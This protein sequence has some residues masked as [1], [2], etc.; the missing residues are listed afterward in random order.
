MRK[1][2]R[3]LSLFLSALFIMGVVNIRPISAAT[4]FTAGDFQVVLDSHRSEISYGDYFE[5]FKGLEVHMEEYEIDAADYVRTDNMDVLIFENF[6]GME[7]KSVLTLEEGVI[8]WEVNVSKA[9]LYNV[10]LIYFPYTG[11]SSDIQ[12]SIFINGILPFAEAR[13]VE[14]PRIWVNEEKIARVDSQ[15]NDVKPRQ[16]EA[17][18]WRR[19]PIR[20]YQG[21]YNE[22]FLF[23]LEEGVNTISIVS[24]REPMM[25]RKLI[26]CYEP[27]PVS[28]KEYEAGI[29]ARY[30]FTPGRT[31]GEILTIEAESAQKKSS[32]M[33]YPISDNSNLSVQPNSARV[34]RNNSIGG[35]KWDQ[36]GQWIE[37]EFDVEQ[38]GF[39]RIGLN[40]KQHFARDSDVYRRISINDEVL[41]KEL[42]AYAF[43]YQRSWRTETLGDETGDFMFYLTEGRHTL[44]MEVVLGE[45]AFYVRD[46][47]ERVIRLNDIYR[48][49]IMI[50][51]AEPDRNRDY[52]VKRTLPNLEEDMLREGTRLMEVYN[53]LAELRGSMGGRYAALRT[54]AEEML[55]IAD[56]VEDINQRLKI[57]KTCIG[58]LGTWIME[59]KSMPLQIDAFFIVPYEEEMPSRKVGWFRNFLHQVALLFYSFFIDYNNIGNIDDESVVTRETITVWVGTGRDQATTL[60][61]LTDEDFKK[62]TGIGVNLMIVDMGSLL[63]ATLAGQGPDVALMVGAIAAGGTDVTLPTNYGLRGAVTDLTQF[64]DFDEVITRFH[65]SGL[66]PYTFRPGER[67]GGVFALPETQSFPMLFYRKDILSEMG[68]E[69]PRTWEDVRNS[70]T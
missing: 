59:A 18:E 62:S 31:Q 52:L 70:L 33:L 36:S 67:G 37:W 11:K 13:N 69:I 57:Y 25:I 10:A 53:E 15:G 29:R 5:Q 34:L 68:L 1:L 46:M 32:P 39:Y 63:P 20:D 6:E 64:A 40:L 65:P 28:Y 17:P 27:S 35:D 50:T 58:A 22:P 55:R 61:T 45:M 26:F 23:Y 30:G 8:E 24:Q 42:S 44:R 47:E 43:G 14:F 60:K 49:I 48:E 4:D 54:A 3:P 56:D 7:G 19:L 16:I 21:F 12:R 38:E 41:F 9:G 66:V 51:S 2:N